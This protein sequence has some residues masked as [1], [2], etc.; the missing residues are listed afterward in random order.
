[1]LTGELKR[2]GNHLHWSP[3]FL[4]TPAGWCSPNGRRVG[5]VAIDRGTWTEYPRPDKNSALEFSSDSETE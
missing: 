2:S 4:S 1:M 3:K 5:P